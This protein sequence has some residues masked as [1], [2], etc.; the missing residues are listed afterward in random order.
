MQLMEGRGEPVVDKSG[1]VMPILNSCSQIRRFRDLR[2]WR[3]GSYRDACGY[4][5]FKGVRHFAEIMQ[6]NVLEGC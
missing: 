3:M 4:A 2:R 6:S 5:R 1:R